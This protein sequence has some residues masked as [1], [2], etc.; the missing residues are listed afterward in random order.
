MLGPRAVR[1]ASVMNQTLKFYLHPARL[2]V[3]ETPREKMDHPDVIATNADVQAYIKNVE[4][5]AFGSW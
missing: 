3:I 5:A 1:T 2:E 4:R